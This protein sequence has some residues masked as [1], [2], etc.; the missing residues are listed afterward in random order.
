MS[1]EEEDQDVK[2]K[3]AGSRQGIIGIR[4]EEVDEEG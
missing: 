2:G 4:R 1:R 3:R